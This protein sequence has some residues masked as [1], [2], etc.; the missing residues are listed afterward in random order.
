MKRI[1][2]AL[3]CLLVLL[4]GCLPGA[5]D[6]GPE[7][8]AKDGEDE[9]VVISEDIN[10]TERY[11]R[12]VIP[13]SPGSSRGFILNG[14]D[15]RLDID[16]FETGLM[17][18]SQEVFDPDKYVLQEGHILS[19]ED[20]QSWIDRRSDNKKGLNPKLGVGKSASV[21]EKLEA[22]KKNPKYLSFV[23][24]QDYFVQ[25]KDDNVE[26]AG[27]SIGISLNSIYYFTVTDKE[28]KIHSGTVDLRKDQGKVIAEGKKMAQ[29]IVNDIREKKDAKNVPIMV[30]IYQE[31]AQES[32]IPGRF[33]AYTSVGGGKTN[34]GNWE[35]VKERY[36]LL[37]SSEAMKDHRGDAEK[38]DNF[39]SKVEGFFPN[40]TGVVGRAFYKEG[41]L[42]RM[43]IEIPMQFYGKSEII[44]F[45]QYVTGL[46]TSNL[47]EDIPIEVYISSMG[48]Q[49]AIIVKDPHEKEPFVHI[50]R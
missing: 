9:K 18:I 17:R 38:F 27:I 45:T 3:I 36:Y 29:Q 42:Q 44:A 26:L 20:I 14:V 11:Y 22:N 32:L 47:F 49:E 43:T 6:T 31:E 23:L 15:N 16:E 4:S 2:L 21:K 37:P 46:V 35:D 39:K 19:K 24:E 7:K 30:A 33:V 13:Y 34:I 28:G 12:S 8:I 10:T 1:L 50:Y 48:R 41:E 25:K 5:P 40:F